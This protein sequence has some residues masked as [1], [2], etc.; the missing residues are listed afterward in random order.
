M[1]NPF[2]GSLTE[3]DYEALAKRAISRELADRAGI[4]RVD[5]LTGRLMF[6]RKQGDLS[7]LIIPNIW[8]GRIREYRLRLDYPP[9]EQRGDGTFRETGKYLQPPGRGNLIYFPPGISGADLQIDRLL[10]ICEGEFKTLATWSLAQESG[11]LRFVPI[12]LAGVYSW[13][14]TVGKT[15]G[16]DGSRRDV[17]GLISD[18]DQIDWKGRRVVIAFDADAE[19]NPKVRAARWAL[20]SVLIELGAKVGNLNWPLADGK[21]IDDWIVKVGAERVLADIQAV[22]FGDWHARLV[23]NDNGQVLVCHENLVL[24]FENSPEWAGV[25]GFNEFTASP[26]LCAPAPAPV[27]L[28]PCAELADHFDTEATCWFERRGIMAKLGMV[29]AVVDVIARRRLVH[30]VRDFLESLPPWDRTPRLDTWTIDYCTVPSSDSD[31]NYFAMRA[32]EKFMIGAVAR[33]VKPGSK[34]DTMPVFEGKQGIGKSGIGRVLAGSEFFSDTALDLR[35]KD[36]MEQLVGTWIFEWS[37]LE[38]L[39]KVEMAAVK[40]FVSSPID[41]YRPSYGRRVVTRPRQCV[42]IG[43]T[44]S[45]AWLRDE[46]GG[47]RFWPLACAGPIDLEGLERVRL[48]LWAEALSR[49][50]EGASWWLDEPEIVRAAAEETGKRHQSDVWQETIARWLIDPV[51]RFDAHGNA[52]GQFSSDKE[53]VTVDDILFHCIGKATQLW[54]HADKMRVSGCLKALGWERFKA[55][56]RDGRHSRYHKAAR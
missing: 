13:R 14:G 2:G 15:V 47:R 21:G 16:A 35:S 18:F 10:V 19:K 32:G 25:L 53:S 51:Q 48:Q 49:F 20:T 43:S 39:S 52:V 41:R 50:R 54:V 56:P 24:Y 23:R 6:G 42:F 37:E 22:Q 30:P 3:S 26:C 17:K 5:S 45:D 11:L 31:P 34:V 27:S 33:V 12:G 40:A 4:R 44:N 8:N 38:A 55:G 46:T 1:D 7:G 28:E 36:C 9:V 29:R